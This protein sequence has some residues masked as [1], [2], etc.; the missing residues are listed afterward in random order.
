M[1]S[2]TRDTLG[3]IT[4]SNYFT[5]LLFLLLMHLF[6]QLDASRYGPFGQTGDTHT[7]TRTH[8]T[9]FTLAC[10]DGLMGLLFS[11][12]PKNTRVL[13]CCHRPACHRRD[14]IEGQLRVRRYLVCLGAFLH[15]SPGGVE[16]DRGLLNSRPGA[17]RVSWAENNTHQ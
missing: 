9:V 10:F 15:F 4:H 2:C 7:R 12:A 6:T 17:G 1:V 8:A 13:P 11:L 5:R 16:Q 3:T 14:L